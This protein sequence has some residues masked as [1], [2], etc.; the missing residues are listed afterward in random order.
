MRWKTKLTDVAVRNFRKGR[1]NMTKIIQERCDAY[2]NG[3]EATVRN[4]AGK[5]I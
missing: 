1:I 4:L 3:K 5:G 2:G